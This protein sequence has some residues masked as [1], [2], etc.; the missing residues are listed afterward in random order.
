MSNLKLPE[1][2]KV[3]PDG[4]FV[5]EECPERLPNL[6]ATAVSSFRACKRLWWFQKVAKVQ[7]IEVGR[8]LTTG[9]AVHD[10]LE[11]YLKGGDKPHA[12]AG[13]F[14]AIAAA[15][16]DLLPEPNSVGV[17][18]WIK[19]VKCGPLNFKGK[20]DMYDL[21]GSNVKNAGWG[22]MPWIG[23]HKT[24]SDPYKWGKT[25]EELSVNPQ[26]LAYAY[27]LIASSGIEKPEKV[28]LTHVYYKT[29]GRP[30]GVRV[31]T[32]TT[33][34][35]IEENWRS[36]EKDAQLMEVLAKE[37]SSS[38]VPSN[39]GSC[40]RFGGCPMA[41]ICFDSPQNRNKTR[42][43]EKG[44]SEMGKEDLR[45]WLLGDKTVGINPPDAAPELNQTKSLLE[46]T[47]EYL[48]EALQ[49]EGGSIPV[50]AYEKLKARMGASDDNAVLTAAGAGIVDGRIVLGE[51]PP[52]PEA[53]PEMD[54]TGE[55]A[56]AIRA[57][58]AQVKDSGVLTKK[59]AKDAAKQALDISRLTTK[60][61][62]AIVVEAAAAGLFA[63]S[64]DGTCVESFNDNHRGHM[65]Q[66]PSPRFPPVADELEE[67]SRIK[68]EELSRTVKAEIKQTAGR[69]FKAPEP[70]SAGQSTVFVDCMP[71]GGAIDFAQW[72][73][74]LEQEVTKENDNTWLYAMDYAKGPPLLAAQLINAIKGGRKLPPRMY[75]STGH[76]GSSAC[77]PVLAQAGALFVRAVK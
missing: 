8:S 21:S 34:A 47:A 39:T 31:D 6:S 46:E 57:I 59:R 43:V 65:E 74:D 12:R 4:D 76:P 3:S 18:D 52:P 37:T 48:K 24:S 63:M 54:L 22:D 42:T 68:A 25:P 38:G 41:E 35:K 36:L 64:D 28:A 44:D 13:Q 67:L 49:Q 73:A 66:V 51:E 9:I 29:R 32:E 11:S 17:E 33:W 40:G 45:A 62:E 10:I 77:I 58:Y 53:R 20:V 50:E 1:G 19:G 7:E 15:G 70:E 56:P 27:G 14:E 75:V 30:Q 55:N 60:R 5:L 16:L 72:V 71:D 26:L 2:S 61:F 23:D 69:T